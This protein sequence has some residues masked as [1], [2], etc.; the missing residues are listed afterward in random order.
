[1][2]PRLALCGNVF[3]VTNAEDVTALMTDGQLPELRQQWLQS[4]DGGA[5]D[6]GFGLYLPAQAAA[7][8]KKSSAVRRRWIKSNLNS[9]WPI[10]T[11]NAFPY[12][13]FHAKLVKEKA[14]LPDWTQPERLQYT[15]QVAD[16]LA[17]QML[18]AGGDDLQGSLSTCPL[19]YG[20]DLATDPIAL[21]HLK[22]AE[23][24]LA[25]IADELQVHLVLSLEP[26]PDG[27]FERVGDLARW[28]HNHFPQSRHVG[29]CWDLCHSAVVDEA[30]SEVVE[31]LQDL[32]VRCGKVQISAALLLQSA[33]ADVKALLAKLADDPWFHQVRQIGGETAVGWPD[34]PQ[35]LQSS[36]YAD[37]QKPDAVATNFQY[38]I[39][40]HV[41]V[42]R[43]Q[44]LPG[45]Q[46]TA[47]KSA[48]DVALAAGIRDFE[49]E[50]YTLP[51]LPKSFLEQ[52][53]VV[54]TF[55]AE[56]AACFHQI[57]LDT[58]PQDP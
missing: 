15:C 33:D 19:G 14:F 58:D 38:G 27:A 56:L 7:Q 50:T 49:L 51:V 53:G 44:F 4:G 52:Q 39:H 46:A 34:L 25:H 3:R 57:S 48:V 26:E 32:Q 36:A 21:K 41:P 6:V 12:G 8:L 31:V 42:H 37:L 1:L 22:L 10:W 5:E 24:H 18:A 40:C 47:W 35:F 9:G 43:N 45:L 20:P 23:A 17:A 13:G 16:L 30:A 54:G 29:V 11:A 2:K 28:L 55:V